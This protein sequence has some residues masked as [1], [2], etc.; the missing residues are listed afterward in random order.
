MYVLTTVGNT[1]EAIDPYIAFDGQT[2]FDGG[3]TKLATRPDIVEFFTAF[4]PHI[5]VYNRL[6]QYSI[7]IED[8]WPTKNCW[9]KLLICYLGQSVVNQTKLLSYKYPRVPGRDMKVSDMCASIA[10][11]L[12]KRER[13]VLP[14]QLGKRWKRMKMHVTRNLRSQVI[15]PLLQQRRLHLPLKK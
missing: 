8:Q 7:S 2:G 14:S 6:R 9:L 15:R 5:D 12:R 4:L 1:T 13:R 11:G 3:D 10:A